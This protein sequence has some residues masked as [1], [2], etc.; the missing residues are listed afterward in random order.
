M[1]DFFIY[2]SFFPIN[3]GVNIFNVCCLH[4]ISVFLFNI[5][6]YIIIFISYFFH[7]LE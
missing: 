7:F 3:C 6:H 1:K 5:S 4:V 2:L